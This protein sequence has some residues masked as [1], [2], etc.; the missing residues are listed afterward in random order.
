[1]TGPA[2]VLRRFS[3]LGVV[4]TAAACATGSGGA[5]SRLPGDVCVTGRVESRGLPPAAETV[6]RDAD[7]SV[8]ALSGDG[9]ANVRLL[10]G[11]S[12]TACGG[13]H[14]QGAPL[15]VSGIQLLEVDGMNA[16][17]GQLA[18]TDGGWALSTLHTGEVV[19]LAGVVPQLA[20]AGSQVVWVAGEWSDGV[21]QVRS[22][23]ILNGW[24]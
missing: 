12:V 6:I 17:L 4:A 13:D 10:N 2:P 3:A 24:R 18:R 21:L 15:A 16:A 8:T 22:Y 1:M 7:G 23:G 14:A 5:S 11:A 20:D 9:A 19:R